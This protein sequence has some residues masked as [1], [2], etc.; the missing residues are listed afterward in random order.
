MSPRP[1]LP[2]P[3]LDKAEVV[4]ALQARA[5]LDYFEIKY[6]NAGSQLRVKVCVVCGGDDD[7]VV[8]AAVGTWIC[9]RCDARGDI[10]AL[11]GILVGL[12]AKVQFPRVF[13]VARDIARLSA[14]SGT[15]VCSRS[16]ATA[17]A[18]AD[19]RRNDAAEQVRRQANAR[20]RAKRYWDSLPTRN[21]AGE[22][23]L[24]KRGLEQLIGRDDLVRF[25]LPGAFG[26]HETANEPAVLIRDVDGA[27]LSV[28]CRRFPV[29]GKPKT[30]TMLGCPTEGTLVGSVVDIVAGARVYVTEG[31]FDALTGAVV[32]PGSVVLGATGTGRLPF[33]AELAAPYVLAHGG[34]MHLVPHADDSGAGRT[35]AI[36]AGVAASA[37]GLVLGKTLFVVRLGGHKD[38]NDAWCA[39][40]RP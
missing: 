33:V 31:I 20:Q 9:H 11:V 16:A 19:R 25:T 26:S 37:A 14:R 30:P 21:G 24:S 18:I 1:S 8:S 12:D 23:Y 34:T 2:P 28:T 17:T 27:P 7:M 22:A 13:E 29:R 35:A 32:W 6:R 36:K 10:F 39:G 4:A 3:R 15:A 5:V 40:W 38:L